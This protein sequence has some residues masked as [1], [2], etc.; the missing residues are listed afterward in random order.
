[1]LITTQTSSAPVSIDT[2]IDRFGPWGIVAIILVISLKWIF[3]RLTVQLDNL[4]ASNARIA[5]STFKFTENLAGAVVRASERHDQLR[6]VFDGLIRSLEADKALRREFEVQILK[7]Q[8]GIQDALTKHA[9][10]LDSLAVRVG[11]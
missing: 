7:A 1:M 8:S 3:G 11:R 2:W 4:V 9:V 5:E 10:V 6:G